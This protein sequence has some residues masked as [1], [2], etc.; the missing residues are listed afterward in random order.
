[1]FLFDSKNFLSFLLLICFIDHLLLLL[2][3]NINNKKMNLQ[4]MIYLFMYLNLPKL[5]LQ[6]VK[7]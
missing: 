7:I 5:V 3:F 1:M 6:I 4:F 2:I